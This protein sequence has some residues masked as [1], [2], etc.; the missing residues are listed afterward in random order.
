IDYVDAVKEK[1]MKESRFTKKYQY[2]FYGAL[3]LLALVVLLWRSKS[4]KLKKMK[5]EMAMMEP[6]EKK[7]EERTNHEE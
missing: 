1:D 5:Q 3:A 2:L 4:R 6:V 7:K